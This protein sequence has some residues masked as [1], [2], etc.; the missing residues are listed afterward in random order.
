MYSKFVLQLADHYTKTV[1]L[2]NIID[3]DDSLKL[4]IGTEDNRQLN[5]KGVQEMEEERVNADAA[6]NSSLPRANARPTSVLQRLLRL[7]FSPIKPPA[8]GSVDKFLYTKN[9]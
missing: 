7:P 6:V 3:E 5:L 2:L 9:K 4:P 8:D 1:Q